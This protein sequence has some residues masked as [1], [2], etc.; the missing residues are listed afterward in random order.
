M[1]YGEVFDYRNAEE[2]KKYTGKK[3]LFG[4]NLMAICKASELGTYVG[5][6]ERV[7][8]E[9][10]YPFKRKPKEG[11]PIIRNQFFRPILEDDELMTN[12]QLAE[13]VARGNGEYTHE[14]MDI[15]SLALVYYKD[16]EDN[17]VSSTTLIRRWGDTD[18]VKP[19]KAIYEED[20]K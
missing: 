10:E 20:C 14:D 3:G 6:L 11:G 2:A 15:A 17:S 8:S 5:V 4:E 16:E 19:T 9:D 18:W 1:K 7:V 13:W 12:R